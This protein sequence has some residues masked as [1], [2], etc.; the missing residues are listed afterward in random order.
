MAYASASVSNSFQDVEGWLSGL[1][2]G[3][4]SW[5]A[6]YFNAT[7]EESYQIQAQL[8]V[9]IAQDQK[10]TPFPHWTLSTQT[11]GLRYPFVS[12][13]VSDWFVGGLVAN[14]ME[15]WHPPGVFT[16]QTVHNAVDFYYSLGGLINLYA[17]TLSAGNPNDSAP[18][19]GYDYV[20][21]PDYITYSVNT[22]LHPRLWS[23]NAALVYQWWLQRSNA[24]ITASY[25][26]NGSQSTTT[27]SITGAA[28]TNTSVE[29]LIRQRA[30]RLASRFSPTAP[31]QPE[32]A[33][34]PMA[35]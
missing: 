25:S 27:F 21:E 15:A 20:L 18:E 10:L 26:T 30:R 28:N 17:H 22:N 19:G 31:W 24:Q 7:R 29:L 16:S 4:R 5:V 8:G 11:S 33:I 3:L 14:S 2:N 35:R 32:T 13:P 6:C 34:G 12:L 9:N 23:A 1:T